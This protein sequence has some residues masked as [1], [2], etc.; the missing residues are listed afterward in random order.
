MAQLLGEPMARGFS[1]KACRK[2]YPRHFL[3][4]VRDVHIGV[5]FRCPACV[6]KVFKGHG[7]FLK[8]LYVKH[9]ELQGIKIEDYITDEV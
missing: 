8:H 3:V 1:C 7:S 2:E 6:D 9:R 5:R 4:H